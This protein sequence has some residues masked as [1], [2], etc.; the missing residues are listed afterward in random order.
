M[1]AKQQVNKLGDYIMENIPGEPNQ[2]E[3]A[4]DVAIRLLEK[5]RIALEDIT[6]E[7]GVPQANYPMPVSNAWKI[8]MEALS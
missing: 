5:Y 2:S 1:S 7:L 8:A 6:G 4:V 3:G